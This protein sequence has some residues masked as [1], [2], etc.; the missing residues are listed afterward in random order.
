MAHDLQ[1]AIALL[2]LTPAVLNALL[3]DLPET[4]T[5][6]NEGEKSRNA[7]DI[8]R[9]LIH[10]EHINW[11]PR[12]KRLLQFGETRGFASLERQGHVQAV[13]GKSLAQLLDEFVD[14]RSEIWMNC[15]LW[16]CSHRTCSGVVNISFLAV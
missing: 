13:Q 3:R 4:W 6:G 10:C 9:H 1:N 14:V 8:V 16:I 11:M 5:L 7:V 15:R 2:A 12:V